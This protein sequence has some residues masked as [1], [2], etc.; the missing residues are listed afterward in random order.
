MTH[1]L[2]ARGNY[3]ILTV[4]LGLGLTAIS[5]DPEKGAAFQQQATETAVDPNEEYVMV[6]TIVNFPMYVSHDQQAFKRWGAKRGVKTTILGPSDWNVQQ[7][8]ATIEQIIPTQPAGLL[9][10]GTDPAIASAIDKAVEAGIPTVVYD[11]DIPNSDRHAFLGTN[12]YDIGRLQGE[13]MV[14]LIDGKGKIAYMGI[15]GMTNMENG[16][17]GL[18]DVIEKYPDIEVVGKF[19]DQAN[20][21][22]AARITADL[23]SAHPDLAGIC[24]FDAMSGP[25]I[26]LAI[27]EANKIG[28]VKVTTVDWEPEHL[29][30][31]KDGVIDM[32]V[33]QK[34]EL[35]T[36]YGA[37]F[38]YDMV[39]NTNQ[40]SQND[41]QAGIT[42]VPYHVN[43]GLLT[44]TSDNISS[45]LP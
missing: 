45:F 5:C 13:E 38:L 28:Q 1:K 7:Q 3:L 9:I 8:I 2:I 16:F 26:G 32:L 19:D 33:G 37:Q 14:K 6:T 36:W 24:G 20:V 29:R 43:T 10:N 41:E 22:E 30:L 25:G 44:I 39:H 21:E 27:K 42:N 35:F 4:L 23:L 11:S 17:R 15:L 40:L 31:V 18:L 34:R 12:W